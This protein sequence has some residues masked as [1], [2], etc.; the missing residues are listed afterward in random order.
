M[1]SEQLWSRLEYFLTELVPVA[2]EAGVRL[3][4]Y[5]DD[6]P[7]DSLPGTARLVNRP[8]R[9]QRLLDV[10][11]SHYN[12]LEF[13]QGTTAEMRGEMDV[14]AAIDRYAGQGKL[15]YHFRNV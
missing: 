1:T 15:G 9:Y 13:C 5:P 12:A 3:A 11:P 4:A 6:P 14:Y 2:E 10:V 8:E 7:L